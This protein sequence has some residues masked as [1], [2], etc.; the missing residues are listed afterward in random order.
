MLRIDP[1]FDRLNPVMLAA[2]GINVPN[3]GSSC[4][5]PN[6]PL[7]NCGETGQVRLCLILNNWI[8]IPRFSGHLH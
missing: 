7:G 8:S 1:H 4:E 5:A 2:F 6:V 3:R